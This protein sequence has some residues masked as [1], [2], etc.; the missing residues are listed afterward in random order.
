MVLGIIGRICE[1]ENSWHQEI[2]SQMKQLETV[3]GEIHHPPLPPP[4]ERTSST[5]LLQGGASGIDGNTPLGVASV[6]GCETV[7]MGNYLF[8]LICDL[9]AKVDALTKHSKNTGVISQQVAFSSEV[10]FNY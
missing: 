10:E 4:T 3:L 2:K 8:G 5:S 9:Q 1:K 6:G 7:I